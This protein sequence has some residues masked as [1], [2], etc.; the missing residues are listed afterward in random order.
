M[1]T[2]SS[3]WEHLL[4]GLSDWIVFYFKACTSLSNQYSSGLVHICQMNL[5][6]SNSFYFNIFWQLCICIF[7]Q[8]TKLFYIKMSRLHNV[9]GSMT[10]PYLSV[11]GYCLKE[12]LVDLSMYIMCQDIRECYDTC[13]VSVKHQR[14]LF[15]NEMTMSFTIAIENLQN[16]GL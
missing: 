1:P 14:Q 2:K 12:S 3:D 5:H 16:L 4:V 11:N 6:C 9:W 7:K 15:G 10:W 13:K 8:Y